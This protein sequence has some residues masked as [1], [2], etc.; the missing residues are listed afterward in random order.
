[1]IT[2]SLGRTIDIA[3]G[4][5]EESDGSCG[6]TGISM[7][8][9]LLSFLACLTVVGCHPRPTCGVTGAVIE[10]PCS[11][12]APPGTQRCQE[13]GTL[14]VCACVPAEEGSGTDPAPP[15]VRWP[16]T[17]EIVVTSSYPLEVELRQPEPASA[18]F[19]SGRD[20]TPEARFDGVPTDAVATILVHGS[21]WFQELTV[22]IAPADTPGSSWT[23]EGD[24]AIWA[25]DL[26]DCEQGAV[27]GCLVFNLELAQWEAAEFVWRSRNVR[28]FD[29]PEMPATVELSSDPD[30]A[31]LFGVPT[32][33]TGEP[34]TTP[35][36]YS[37]AP[38]RS[39][40]RSRLRLADS[41]FGMQFSAVLL[42]NDPVH[43]R[44]D[45]GDFRCEA[46]G[47][48]AAS[49]AASGSWEGVCHYVAE[50][51]LVLPPSSVESRQWF[52]SGVPL[53]NGFLSV[54]QVRR[55]IRRHTRGNRYCFERERLSRSG[56]TIV[57]VS[58]T[59][60][61]SG[62]VASAAVVQSERSNRDLEACLVR[63]ARR[64]RFDEPD[65]GMVV[66]TQPY[67]AHGG[68]Q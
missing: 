55:V 16:T 32:T 38:T 23:L 6:L 5:S 24:R 45:W 35:F 25:L 27:G 29:P 60:D 64:F 12:G 9:I 10:C 66:V 47:H 68:R 17:G 15:E 61:L 28:D 8:F 62:R 57:S 26:S 50:A 65:G 11:G 51:N 37:D 52:V 2:P 48:A 56:P 21:H 36:T 53:V 1:M 30:G 20:R 13:D 59:V 46:D 40:D 58:L 42:G 33:S 43:T 4:L 19:F 41:R 7:R 3:S 18:P 22:E 54:E 44:L 49:A 39:G 14:S 31:F 34:Q 67:V 63:E